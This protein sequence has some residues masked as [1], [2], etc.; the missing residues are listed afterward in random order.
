M[1]F[2]LAGL[3]QWPQAVLMMIATT[4]GGYAGAPI[5]RRIPVRVLRALIAC[6]G[7]GMS[8]IFFYRLVA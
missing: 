8:A 6:I 7:F 1:T 5:A 2:S 4:I 3:V